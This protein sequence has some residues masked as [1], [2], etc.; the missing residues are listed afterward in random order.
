M[1]HLAAMNSKMSVLIHKILFYVLF[2]EFHTP[3]LGM[4][5]INDLLR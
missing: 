5:V 2:S 1:L 3:N 4:H